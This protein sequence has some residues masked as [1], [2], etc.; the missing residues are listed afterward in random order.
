M[1]D[2]VW[3]VEFAPVTDPAEVAPTVLAT[4]GI[5]EQSLIPGGRPGRAAANPA[6]PVSR[7]VAALSGKQALLVLDNC[8]H[9][10]ASVAALADRVLGACPRRREYPH[11]GGLSCPVRSEQPED[12]AGPDPEIDPG[13]GNRL[14]EALDQAFGNN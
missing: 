12:R 5:R 1:P 13:Q 2:G 14:A 7:L 10:V 11:R 8:E 3:L 9:L 4:L 6:D